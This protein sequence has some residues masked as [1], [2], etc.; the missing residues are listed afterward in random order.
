MKT[1]KLLSSLCYFSIFFAP[2]LFP[3]IVYFIS[4]D[5]EVKQHAKKSLLSHIIPIV[6]I[7]APF[8]MILFAGM[9]SSPEAFAVGVVIFGF[10]LIGI[11]N[12]VVFI[13]NI[14]QGIK[15]LKTV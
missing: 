11:V 1:D 2:F 14:V 15:I 12:L 6:T 4:D 9:F 10:I 3:I 7:I 13:Y 5:L 8:F